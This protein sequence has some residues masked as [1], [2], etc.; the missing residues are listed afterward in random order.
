MKKR[1][2]M[3]YNGTNMNRRSESAKNKGICKISKQIELYIY[4][5]TNVMRS[6]PPNILGKTPGEKK[7]RS[8]PEDF[9]HVV[10]W[11]AHHVV[12]CNPSLPMSEESSNQQVEP[13]GSIVFQLVNCWLKG[14]VVW[15]S[16]DIP[17]SNDPFHR[18]IPGI[19][20]TNP[21]QQCIIS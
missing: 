5:M 10:S 7:K 19:R 17:L 3:M 20:T 1:G 21:N 12:Q 9:Q 16:K 6:F 18:G 13:Q 14:P 15:D 2:T 11:Y 8:P 4:T